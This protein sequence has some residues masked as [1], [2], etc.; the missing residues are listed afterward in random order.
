M[1]KR[2]R[3]LVLGLSIALIMYIIV[4]SFFTNSTWPKINRSDLIG[5]W[6]SNYEQANYK[7]SYINLP[8]LQNGIH[9]L[10]L[11]EDGM[12]M[13]EYTSFDGK[14]KC[15]NSNSWI[16]E[17]LYIQGRPYIVCSSF[18]FGSAKFQGEKGSMSLPVTKW[19]GSIRITILDDC[20]WYFRK[21]K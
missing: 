19:F 15:K 4:V 17:P 10:T 8:E 16:F 11:R 18:A 6:V 9:R 13:Y 1:K 5:N 20:G 7:H 12:Y 21:G 2:S 14:E 3:N